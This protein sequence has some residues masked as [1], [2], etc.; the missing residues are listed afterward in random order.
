[1]AVK[2]SWLFNGNN[3]GRSSRVWGFSETWYCALTGDALIAAMD[4]VSARR[5]QILSNDSAIVGYRIGQENGRS[6][7][8]RKLFAPPDGNDG[9]NL[10]VDAALCQCQVDGSPTVKKFWLHDL[11]DDWI[12]GGNIVASRRG[13]I[14]LVVDAYAAF[15]FGVRYQQRTAST[16]NVLTVDALG[17]VVTQTPQTF[18]VNNL[19]TFLNCRDVNNR[20][21]RGTYAVATRTDDTHFTLAHWPGNIVSRSG[22]VRLNSFTV[23]LARSMGAL[24]VIEGG[25]RKVGRPFFQSR[26]RASV[27]R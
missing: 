24:G 6:Y 4:L 16:A 26:G 10:P 25:S 18:A 22:R 17:A 15:G 27:R 13:A 20:A 7:V 3:V 11:P 8:V 2:V 14:Q 21:I 9:S 12:N 23:G 19:V 1:M 5:V